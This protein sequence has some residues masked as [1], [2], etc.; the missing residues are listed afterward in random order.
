MRLRLILLAVVWTF[1][2][3]SLFAQSERKAEVFVGY[4]NLQAQ[5][6]P[7]KN[8]VTGIF[9]SNFLND[10]STL[11]GF[12]T[13]VSGFLSGNFGLTGSF[14]FNENKQ[15]NATSFRSDE[16]KTDILYFM[17]GPS[18][19]VGNSSRFQPFVRVMAGGAHTRFNVDSERFLSSGTLTN[20]FDTH[21]TDFAMGAGGGLDWRV[22]DK[23]KVR[24]FQ[25]DYT[26]IFL[27]DQSVRRLTDAGAIEPVTL[28][29]QRMDNVRFV[30]GVVF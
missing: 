5:G 10:R 4:S 17:G 29:G 12:A 23:L 3:V 14:S 15:S 19:K 13:E 16:L 27:G 6:L 21:T 18:F 9:S 7:D 8:N 11:H 2:S 1:S 25:V 26:P 24:L 28:N 20:S 30:F 22:K